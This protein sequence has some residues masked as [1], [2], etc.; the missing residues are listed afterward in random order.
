MADFEIYID[1]ERYSAPSLYLVSAANEARARTLAEQL[2]NASEHH[3]GV[4]LRRQDERIYALGSFA[5]PGPAAS[6]DTARV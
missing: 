4:E 1:D 5:A 6:E 3:R 2:L